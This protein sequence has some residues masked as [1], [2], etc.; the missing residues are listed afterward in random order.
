[1]K[2]R[3]NVKLWVFWKFY[4]TMLCDESGAERSVPEA[5]EHNIVLWNFQKIHN[6]RY[7][8]GGAERAVSPYYA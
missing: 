1:M 8:Q 6:I 7:D 2:E 3:D 5:E 4:N